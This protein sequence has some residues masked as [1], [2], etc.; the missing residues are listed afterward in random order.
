MARVA[1]EKVNREAIDQMTANAWQA[2]NDFYQAG[3][4]RGGP[5]EA[6][7][8]VT[9]STLGY[10]LFFFPV[11]AAPEILKVFMN[12][13]LPKFQAE[14]LG[15]GFLAGLTGVRDGLLQRGVDINVVNSFWESICYS[16][17]ELCVL[18][19]SSFWPTN[20]LIIICQTR[21][22]SA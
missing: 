21:L 12:R 20:V 9:S 7:Y 15:N 17:H 10:W 13:M 19:T 16:L 3:Q 5:M 4:P 14:E 18:G 1:S 2:L 22:I 6:P 11:L 8:A